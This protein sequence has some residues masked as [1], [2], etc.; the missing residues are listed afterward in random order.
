MRRGCRLVSIN[1]RL[2]NPYELAFNR[3]NV[4][5]FKSP[6]YIAHYVMQSHESYINR[7]INLPTD[8]TGGNR[9]KDENIHNSHN[10]FENKEPFH[11]Y[12]SKVKEFLQ[13]IG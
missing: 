1:R 9:G 5:Y 10:G 6:A 11:K 7:K 8:D 13:K 2:M 3:W 4:E 12:A